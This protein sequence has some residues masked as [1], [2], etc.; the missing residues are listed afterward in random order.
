M[1][2][3]EVPPAIPFTNQFTA[4]LVVPETVALNCCVWPSWRL[5]LVG[6]TVTVTGGGGIT[7]TAAFADAAGCAT[8]SAITVIGEPGTWEGAV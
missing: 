6:E 3:A 4:V 1:P 2:T 7:V 5:A 8:L